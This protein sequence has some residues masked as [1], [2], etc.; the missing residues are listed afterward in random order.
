MTEKRIKRRRGRP[1]KEVLVLK[2]NDT[3]VF[4]YSQ[5]VKQKAY[6]LYVESRVRPP[7][8]LMSLRLGI[9]HDSLM[10]WIRDEEWDLMRKACQFWRQQQLCEELGIKDAD[11][12]EKD[13]F[14][15]LIKMQE[16]IGR[17]RDEILQT[18]TLGQIANLERIMSQVTI[19]LQRVKA[20]LGLID[21]EDQRY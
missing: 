19:N 8:K 7:V 12:A 2:P 11:A 10:G 1:R 18:G 5:K 4:E 20:S 21:S 9:H 15:S 14:K 6:E 16:E 17:R 13:I 3:G